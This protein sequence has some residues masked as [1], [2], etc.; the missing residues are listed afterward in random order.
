MVAA[1]LSGVRWLLEGHTATLWKSASL[2]LVARTIARIDAPRE[3]V[4]ESS[5]VAA[6]GAAALVGALVVGLCTALAPEVDSAIRGRRV[7]LTAVGVT[8]VALAVFLVTGIE[9]TPHAVGEGNLGLTIVSAI[10]W[11]LLAALFFARVGTRLTHTFPWHGALA[12]ATAGHG[13]VFASP[14]RSE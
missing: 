10:G 9:V 12:G 2:A 3:G 4:G 5:F 1:A 13:L 6:F 14:P 11:A 7:A 8:A